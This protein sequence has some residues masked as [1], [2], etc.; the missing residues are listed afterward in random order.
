LFALKKIALWNFK[1]YAHFELAFDHQYVAFSGNN[2]SGKTN[3]LDAIHYASMGKSY[4]N[5][6]DSQL[7]RHDT[8]AFDLKAL[9]FR[10]D[11]EYELLCSFQPGKKKLLK[12][13]QVEYEKLA[14]HVGEFPVIMITP[15]ETDII[16]GSA[17]I[18]RR[19]LDMAI[20]Q[21][22]RSYMFDLMDYNKALRQRNS[23]IKYMAEHDLHDWQLIEAYDQILISKG[24]N[25]FNTRKEYLQNF[26]E[27]LKDYYSELS[28]DAEKAN[29]RY[30]SQ[31]L[32]QEI[33]VL[34]KE[35]RKKDLILR[36]SNYGIHRDDLDFFLNEFP[37][38]KYA[39]QGQQK[40]FII[41]LKLAQY[42]LLKREKSIKAL[43]LI[44]DLFDRLDGERS[45][46]LIKIIRNDEFGQ[47]FISD[48]SGEKIKTIFGA[49][50]QLFHISNIPI[51]HD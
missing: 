23:R 1:N 21:V 31:L 19:F 35:N 26:G 48:T 33:E 5:N 17:E 40:S 51:K 29:I 14:D 15:Y 7:I 6:I 28:G 25:I 10:N 36:R 20:A 49:N 8:F 32:N 38:K 42:Y 41:A 16:H 24:K 12:L 47:V 11:K 22:N 2:G 45:S 50:I 37:L 13:N 43:V 3:L 27:F 4:F 30:R 18:R 46:R 44:D 34:L 9:F 39:S